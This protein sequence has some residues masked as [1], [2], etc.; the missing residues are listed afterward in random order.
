MKTLETAIFIT[1]GV[2]LVWWILDHQ[3]QPADVLKS[4]SN[5][6]LAG[7]IIDNE[8]GPTNQDFGDFQQGYAETEAMWM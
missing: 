3:V 1:I 8:L 2:G 6:Q 7:Q 4:L 5:S